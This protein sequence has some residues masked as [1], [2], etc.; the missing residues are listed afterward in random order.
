MTVALFASAFYPHV[1]GVEELCRQLAHEYRA[2]GDGI[3]VFTERW[4]RTLPLWPACP[5]STRNFCGGETNRYCVTSPMRIS[6]SI[7]WGLTSV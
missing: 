1:G 5:R 7:S 2:R 6:A 4:P 3:A